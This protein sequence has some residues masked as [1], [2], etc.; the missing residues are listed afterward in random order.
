MMMM[1]TTTTM[2][3]PHQKKK[4]K[5]DD[6]DDAAASEKKADDDDA[7]ASE[8][9]ADDDE[10]G[11]DDNTAE[12]RD[13]KND[14]DASAK[15]KK[16][17]DDDDDKANGKKSKKKKKKK[18]ADDDDDGDDDDDDD[19]DDDAV[20]NRQRL[21]QEKLKQQLATARMQKKRAAEQSENKA[22]RGATKS[23]KAHTSGTEEFEER[24]KGIVKVIRKVAGKKRAIQVQK[25]LEQPV[26]TQA[27]PFRKVI[28][29]PKFAERLPI[30]KRIIRMG[31]EES[32]ILDATL[33]FVQGLKYGIFRSPKALADK[34]K[35]A[36]LDWLQLLHIA[37]PQEW[38]I[39]VL[40]DDLIAK[41][42]FVAQSDSNLEKV[43]S[44]HPTAR[45]SWSA[46]CMNGKPGT[47]FSC[48]FWKLLHI[49]TV[50]LAQHKGGINLINADMVSPDSRTFAPAEAAD[51]LR[52]YMAN[53]YP[54]SDCSQHFMYRYDDC[55]YHRCDR[56][57]DEITTTTDD[58]WKAFSLWL[59]EFHNEVSV[60][61]LQER[62]ASQKA[63]EQRANLLSPQQGP[64]T[65]SI[66]DEIQVLWP[67]LQE[68]VT[69]Y[70]ADGK[71]D[72]HAVFLHLEKTYWPITG[73]D[74][75]TARLLRF[76]DDIPSESGLTWL[77]V[78]I[79]SILAC[80]MRQSL[81][82]RTG[83]Q[84]TILQAKKIRMQGGG[85]R[86]RSD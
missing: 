24:K 35:K 81:F 41:I 79:G 64:V 27:P 82:S 3:L 53:F 8:K 86:K 23:M 54:C 30:L 62:V 75:K 49:L 65:P 63:K 21:R 56:L 10:A 16:N 44:A 37:L 55:S 5:V 2:Q 58:G 22:T 77:L 4:K 39:H 80:F 17:D 84:Q 7:A 51:V 68:C 60:R 71:W 32:M 6:D 29:A 36:L 43:L 83:L 18:K 61:I 31:D 76:E 66:E 19:D 33:S 59:W 67:T 20:S 45:N 28:S 26:A 72:R 73:L 13:K 40:I 14:D 85:S 9:K 50:G 52:E 47:G 34:E 11:D 69:C 25:K 1:M 42:D 46:S 15:K 48:G 70:K 78:V 57:N 38:A 74:A 12:R